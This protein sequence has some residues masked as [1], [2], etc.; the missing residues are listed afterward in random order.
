MLD[1]LWYT[2]TVSKEIFTGTPVF[3]VSSTANSLWDITEIRQI[4]TWTNFYQQTLSANFDD[5]D[6]NNENK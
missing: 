2:E 1:N 6:G 3:G 5:F 4:L